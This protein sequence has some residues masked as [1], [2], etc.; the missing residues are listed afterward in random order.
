MHS[1]IKSAF[2]NAV[3]TAAYVAAVASFLFY[4]PKALGENKET[5]LIPIAM[6]M[7]FVFSAGITGFLVIGKP[8]LWYLDGR[9]QEAV[10]LLGTTLTILFVIVT[11]VFL[12]LA[13]SR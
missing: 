8:I 2:V 11:A 4:T 9:K 7:L 1:V 5:V 6:L 13:L 10:A 3:L 12:L